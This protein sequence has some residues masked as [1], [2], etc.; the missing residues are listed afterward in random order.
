VAVDAGQLV[1]DLR[2]ATLDET[3]RQPM[4]DRVEAVGGSIEVT[5]AAGAV[6]VRVRIPVEAAETA[7]AGSTT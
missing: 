7:T 2:V 1:V 4:V 6:H 3:D 5:P